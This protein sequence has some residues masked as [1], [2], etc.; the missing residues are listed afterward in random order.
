MCGE[1]GERAGSFASLGGVFLLEIVAFGGPRTQR[2]CLAVRDDLPWHAW[3]AYRQMSPPPTTPT[4]H[5][6]GPL[7]SRPPVAKAA[8][9]I[10]HQQPRQIRG[11]TEDLLV[12]GH[13]RVSRSVVSSGGGTRGGLEVAAEVD[14]VDEERLRSVES[15]DDVSWSFLPKH[16]ASIGTAWYGQSLFHVMSTYKLRFV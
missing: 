4:I 9:L 6:G 13:G 3:L 12:I 1:L 11:E 2:W 5:V 15:S 16:Q 7:P 10:D 14:V 8:S